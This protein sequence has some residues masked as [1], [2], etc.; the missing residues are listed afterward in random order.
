MRLE[1]ILYVI[2]VASLLIALVCT[3]IMQNRVRQACN[4][5]NNFINSHEKQY[6]VKNH[7]RKVIKI[8]GG[9]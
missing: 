5:M 3:I 9:K 4:Y 2:Q 8:L 6:A 7:F 1:T